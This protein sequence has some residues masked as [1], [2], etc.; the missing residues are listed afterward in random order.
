M[1]ILY[2]PKSGVIKGNR[3]QKEPFPLDKN[4]ALFFKKSLIITL[5]IITLAF[6]KQTQNRIAQVQTGGRI[7]FS[8]CKILA[9]LSFC[10][11]ERRG[12]ALFE[13]RAGF[14]FSYHHTL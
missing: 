8:T 3:P 11:L 1:S 12:F 6:W 10:M 7:L 13:G 4:A 2:N 5:L 9:G 14:V